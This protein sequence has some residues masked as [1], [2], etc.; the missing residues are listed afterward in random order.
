MVVTAT[1]L[2]SLFHA[3][4]CSP[5]RF[6]KFNDRNRLWAYTVSDSVPPVQNGAGI[7]DV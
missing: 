3:M 5:R 1:G 6:V 2:L 4:H 7:Y